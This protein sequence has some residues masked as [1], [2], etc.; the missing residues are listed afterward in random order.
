MPDRPPAV[1]MLSAEHWPSLFPAAVLHR[2]GELVACDP[3]LVVDRF[4]DPRLEG[5]LADV[6]VLITGWGCP[7]I[8]VPALDAMPK[9]RAVLH[10]AGSV[11]GH[12]CPEVWER[13]IA[14]SS[15]AAANA[16]PVAEYALGAILLAGKGA[17]G[18]RERYRREQKFELGF[19]HPD[20]GNYG[21][22]VGIVGASRI[23]RQ[24]IDLL[25]PL[26]FRLQVYDPY[27]QDLDVPVVDL[28]TLLATSDIVSVHAPSTPETYQL[29]GRDQL[30]LMP[31][32][33]TIVNTARGQLVDTE[34]LIAELRSGRLAAVIDVTDPEPLPPGSPLF[35]L[36][37][38]FV[39]PHIAG[40]HG[41]E[42][43]RLGACVA[44][45]LQRFL[46][47][48]PLRFPVTLADL[49]RGA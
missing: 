12:L 10:A 16:V 39:T 1:F 18:L 43:T 22:T 45:E 17:F 14:V 20:V 42:L 23:G 40:S 25:R 30:A 28:A 41:N 46:A 5:R 29:L 15:A 35:K 9:L 27:A 38:A 13:G 26:D 6:E 3:A 7:A 33:A 24:V 44:D 2:I 34:A 31:D 37:N 4:D 47:G 49:A 48:D 11:K 32:G 21:R 36:P 19:I 8:D